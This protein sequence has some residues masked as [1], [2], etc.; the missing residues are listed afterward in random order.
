MTYAIYN[1]KNEVLVQLSREICARIIGELTLNCCGY[2][3]MVS[4]GMQ[5]NQVRLFVV[6]SAYQIQ[7]TEGVSI[8]LGKDFKIGKLVY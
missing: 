3:D 5:S 8:S 2:N 4:I 7:L 1:Q 6:S